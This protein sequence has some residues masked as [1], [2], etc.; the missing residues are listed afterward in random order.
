MAPDSSIPL[1]KDAISEEG[2][3]FPLS[4]DDHLILAKNPNPPVDT[5]LKMKSTRPKQK[6][7]TATKCH[8]NLVYRT[9]SCD[10]AAKSVDLKSSPTENRSNRNLTFDQGH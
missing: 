1:H 6:A 8:Q 4:K 3:I 2:A 7:L 5:M 9:V 10:P